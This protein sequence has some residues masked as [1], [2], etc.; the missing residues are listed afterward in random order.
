MWVFLKNFILQRR[1]IMADKNEK[2]E[3]KV[4]EQIE[5]IEKSISF[6]KKIVKFIKD[7]K[8]MF[9]KMGFFAITIIVYCLL[10]N[11]SLEQILAHF[12][13]ETVTEALPVASL[14]M[15]IGGE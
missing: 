9:E 12:L 3:E 5:K 11:P 6:T 15:L 8:K 2:N 7:H 13:G 10:C 4:E 1:K 14:C